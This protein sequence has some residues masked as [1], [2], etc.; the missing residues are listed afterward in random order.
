MAT[1]KA[2]DD[3]RANNAADAQGM[4]ARVKA[5]IARCNEM[6]QRARALP[7]GSQRREVLLRAAEVEREE[8]KGQA[9]IVERALARREL[10]LEA[11]GVD[12]LGL[13]QRE[14]RHTPGGGAPPRG[15]DF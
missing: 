4:R 14:A 8:I 5:R 2:I 9:Q 13:G 3:E 11:G 10:H 7:E 1:I 15:V 6:E 12:V